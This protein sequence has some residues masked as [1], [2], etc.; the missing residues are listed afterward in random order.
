LLYYFVYLEG[1]NTLGIRYYG[2]ENKFV[3]IVSG[4]TMIIKK[5][6][7][8]KILF[9]N[10]HAGSDTEFLKDCV[11]YGFKIYSGDRYNFTLIRHPDL[12]HHTWKITKKD[13]LKKC[14]FITKT[15][16]YKKYVVK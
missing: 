6:V 9:N 12:S 2:N 8:D 15:D 11:H 4:A 1:S 16:N 3:N 7:F 5:K 10:E 14:K 13:I